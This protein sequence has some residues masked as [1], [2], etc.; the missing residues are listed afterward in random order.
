MLRVT[1][2]LVAAALALAAP[3]RAANDMFTVAG[4]GVADPREG[5][6]AGLTSLPEGTPVAA[7]PDGELLLGAFA[8][9]W[10]VD[11]QGTLH[12]VAGTDRDGYT[13]DGGPATLAEVNAAG[14]APL[15]G[16]GFLVLDPYDQR[17]RMVDPDGIITTVAGGG[18]SAADGIPATR[19]A[20]DFPD[21]I[22]ALPG[23]GFVFGDDHDRVREVGPDG[24]IRTIAGGGEDEDVHGQPGTALSLDESG[25]AALAD[26]S[27][28]VAES[29]QGRVERI[30]PD[31]TVR[32]VAQGHDI[33]PT[34]V[35]ALPDGGFAFFDEHDPDHRIWQVS[36]GGAMRVV[37]GG[38]PFAATAPDGLAQLVEGGPA[39]GFDLPDA[40]GL[41][42]LPDGGL[43]FSY[44]REQVEEFDGRVAYIAP[45][46]P[47]R[48]ALG[49]ARD[50]S[51]VFS[52]ARRATLHIALTQPATVAVAVAG[53]TLTRALP[54]GRSSVRL[55]ARLPLK[56][57][58][59]TVTATDA[60]GRQAVQREHVFPVGWLPTETAELVA[61]ALIAH[62][63]VGDCDRVGSRRLDCQVD[64]EPE[65]CRNVT[66]TYV[67]GRLRWGTA[68]CSGPP[69]SHSRPLRRR[70]W[71]CREAGCPPPRLFGRVR[72][73]AII[74]TG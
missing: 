21:A 39:T 10:R 57:D 23:G 12:A 41:A 56:R 9:V 63:D 8:R 24:L 25:V 58:A 67:H 46:A 17:I 54:A 6:S 71:L 1:L 61:G 55:P 48:L 49:L 2:A 64:I 18:T 15:P 16:G 31:G 34:L 42:A 35:A 50:R 44:D 4:G 70:D 36:P 26:G 74:P 37:A 5:L 52:R 3:A 22:A 14:F 51:R 69:A 28:L 59:V 33:E 43:L 11:A 19:A 45:A 66:V 27:V 72:E 60:A 47:G 53:H 32:V 30:A 62:S 13:G 29:Y 7:L 65:R 40:R 68:K 38:G 73:A 20:L